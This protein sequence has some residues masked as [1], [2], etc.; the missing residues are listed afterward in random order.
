MVVPMIKHS[1]SSGEYRN[2][3]QLQPKSSTISNYHSLR[4][5]TTNTATTASNN[6]IPLRTGGDVVMM[7]QEDNLF[8]GCT[9]KQ[10]DNYDVV[11]V[12]LDGNR[13]YPIYIG[14]NFT[15]EQGMFCF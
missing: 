13:D 9:T 3:Q 12:D 6:N 4:L 11:T 5:S 2:Q 14:T 8:L 7:E 1:G 10:Y 15:K